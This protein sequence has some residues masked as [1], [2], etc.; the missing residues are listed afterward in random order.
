MDTANIEVLIRLLA[1][2]APVIVALATLI[3]RIDAL[4]GQTRINRDEIR[5]NTALL[6]RLVLNLREVVC[7][8][9]EQDSDDED[10]LP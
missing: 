9:V 10:F 6:E 2:L 1:E 5:T 8:R 7:D 3:E 4:D